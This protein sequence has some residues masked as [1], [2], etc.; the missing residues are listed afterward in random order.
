MF[1][2]VTTATVRGCYLVTYISLS[3]VFSAF[4]DPRSD[5]LF[6][7]VLVP[8]ASAGEFILYS[9]DVAARAAQLLRQL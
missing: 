2:Q 1:G 7:R 3:A 5:V 4:S 9:A 8:G 6:S